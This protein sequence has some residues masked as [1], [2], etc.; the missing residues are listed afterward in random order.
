[1][2]PPQTPGQ[3]ARL[4][5]EASDGFTYSLSL[6]P[7]SVAASNPVTAAKAWAGVCLSLTKT[8]SKTKT[9]ETPANSPVLQFGISYNPLQSQFG[10]FVECDK[11]SLGI[12]ATM[13]LLYEQDQVI[14]SAV[15]KR[16]ITFQGELFG[17]QTTTMNGDSTDPAIALLPR[18]WSCFK[19][20]RLA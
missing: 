13:D 17:E 16:S 19:A 9:G 18:N 6:D 11:V 7:F 14:I 12:L 20:R 8:L 2:V 5:G 15:L 4:S 10:V 3:I 1:L